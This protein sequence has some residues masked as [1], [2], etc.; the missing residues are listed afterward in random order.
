MKNIKKKSQ[1]DNSQCVELLNRLYKKGICVPYIV[2]VAKKFKIE[3][4][5]RSYYSFNDIIYY[6]PAQ[7]IDLSDDVTPTQQTNTSEVDHSP[8]IND[9]IAVYN[10]HMRYTIEIERLRNERERIIIER[11]I[12]E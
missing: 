8:T 5:G 1:K 7:Q 10:R 3:L 6:D 4:E 12:E 2:E 11:G 9:R